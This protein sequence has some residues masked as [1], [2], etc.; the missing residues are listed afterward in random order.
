MQTSRF[1]L[2]HLLAAVTLCAVFFAIVAQAVRGSGWAIAIAGACGGVLFI[3][4]VHV[5]FVLAAFTLNSL[6]GVF[7]RRAARTQSPFAQDRPPPQWIEPSEPE[8]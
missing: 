8:G 5:V 3:L 4:L 7:S 6:A 1:S 2:K